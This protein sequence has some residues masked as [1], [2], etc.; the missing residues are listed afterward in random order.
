VQENS[1]HRRLRSTRKRGRNPGNLPLD[2]FAKPERMHEL[3]NE[4]VRLKVDVIIAPSS[5]YTGAARRATSTI[6]IVFF[7]HADPSAAVML[8]VS[9]SPA[10]TPLGSR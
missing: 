10:A 9:R 6:P 7:S 8:Q 3:A 4:L 2:D 5:I 1:F